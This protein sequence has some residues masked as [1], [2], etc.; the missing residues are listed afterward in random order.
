MS[1]RLRPPSSYPKIWVTVKRIPRGRV[2][3]YG[4]IAVLAGLP[5]QPRLVGYALHQTPDETI[6]WHRVVN[7]RGEI[8][9]RRAAE[10]GELLQQRLLEN[11]GVEFDGVERI[12]L[13]RFQWRPRSPLKR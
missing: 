3:T 12:D 13:A 1:D 10:G 11:E 2:A 7:A 6:P 5:R 4:Q 8:S 9:H